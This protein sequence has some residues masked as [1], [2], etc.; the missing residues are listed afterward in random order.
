MK[1]R[2]DVS[3]IPY[4]K[5]IGNG[6]CKI[7]VTWLISNTNIFGTKQFPLLEILGNS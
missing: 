1:L 6:A 5:G 3:L 7:I 4:K 2:I